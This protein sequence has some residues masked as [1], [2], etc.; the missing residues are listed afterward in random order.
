MIKK[1]LD[2]HTVAKVLVKLGYSTRHMHERAEIYE[3]HSVKN[4][5]PTTTDLA[6]SYWIMLISNK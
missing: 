4:Y 5:V 3:S 2:K 6:A 1:H